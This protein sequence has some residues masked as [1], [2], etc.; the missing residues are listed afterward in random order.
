MT[1]HAGHPFAD[2]PGRRDAAR[3]FRGRLISP[4]TLWLT[5]EGRRR[6]GMTVSSMLIAL[7]EEPALVGLLDPDSDLAEAIDAFT[8]TILTEADRGLAEAFAGLAPAPGGVFRQAEFTDTDWGPRL[9]APRAWLGARIIDRRPLGW[10]S[11]VTA[12]IEHVELTD[13]DVVLTHL[14]GRYRPVEP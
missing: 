4:V 14:R 12:R 3:Q 13:A 1:I 9:V 6:A 5:G 11:E 2:P 7:G 8:V 10:A